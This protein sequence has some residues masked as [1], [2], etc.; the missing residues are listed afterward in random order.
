[1]GKRFFTILVLIM[2]CTWGNH[3]S[4]SV[5]VPSASANKVPDSVQVNARAAVDEFKSLSGKEKKA[6]LKQARK[7]IKAF[8][9]ARKNGT[10]PDTNTLL[11]VILAILLPP[12]AV[13]LHEGTANN[14][15]WIT[16]L[17]FLL[18]IIGGFL[19]SWA[20]LLASIIYAL[21]VVLGA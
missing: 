12:L 13:Y 21:I 4:A 19:F 20:A 8:K 3:L 11:L 17:L 15:F 10:D 1:M 6:K 5:I 18:G 9:K 7:E 14:K 16:L 2:L